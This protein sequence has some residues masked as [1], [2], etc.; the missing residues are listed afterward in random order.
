M[1]NKKNE[2]K[3]SLKALEKIEVTKVTYVAPDPS[4]TRILFNAI[5]DDRFGVNSM[6]YVEIVKDGKE[7]H[8]ISVPSEKGRDG[9]YYNK[10]SVFIPDALVESV[11]EQIEKMLEE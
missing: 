3:K 6:A 2:N 8:F 7:M 5:L 11:R 1:I 4:K 9:R 10:F